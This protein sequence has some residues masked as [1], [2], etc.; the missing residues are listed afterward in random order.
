MKF[1][2]TFFYKSAFIIMIGIVM[3]SLILDRINMA[4]RN[5]EEGQCINIHIGNADPIHGQI[6]NLRADGR[7]TVN[8]TTTQNIIKKKTLKRFQFVE[9][10]C[11]IN[12]L[13]PRVEENAP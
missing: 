9:T 4:D 1:N 3:L 8:Y 10:S 6:F 2:I 5:L 7:Y 13:Y 11:Q 12:T